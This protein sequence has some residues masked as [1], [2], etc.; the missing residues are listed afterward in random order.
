MKVWISSDVYH[1]FETSKINFL[2]LYRNTPD[3]LKTH[4]WQSWATALVHL[5]DA[6]SDYRSHPTHLYLDLKRSTSMS[7]SV[8]KSLGIGIWHSLSCGNSIWAEGIR[9][10]LSQVKLGLH[11]QW[12]LQSDC[13]CWTYSITPSGVGIS[14][15]RMPRRFS[16]WQWIDF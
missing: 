8:G 5:P 1:D 2:D 12:R 9:L 10:E 14:S 13:V 11:L 7:R 4:L 3:D 16:L 6:T 15:Q